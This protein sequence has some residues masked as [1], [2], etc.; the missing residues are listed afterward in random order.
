MGNPNLQDAVD[1]Q[2]RLWAR[3]AP[4]YDRDM[5]FWERILFKDAR[6]WACAQA[7]G[8]V[9]EVAVGTGR[10]FPFYPNDIRLT[11]VDLSPEMLRI[12]RQRADELGRT[13]GLEEG[14][15]HQL[16]F[17]DASF[18]TVVCTFSL[19]NIPDERRAIAEMYRVLRPGGRLVL[20]DHV[21]STSRVILGLQRLL[22]KLTLRQSGDYLTRRPLPLVEAAGF[23]VQTRQRYGK[24]IVE[25]LTA[26]KPEGTP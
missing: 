6:S 2:R 5:R 7:T 25:R 24:G 10:N 23:I 12:A 21:T 22:E 13:V 15:A 16:S 4:R 8:D 20:A 17:P 11:G 18:D 14:D 9:L 3:Q 19:C 1:R 26:R